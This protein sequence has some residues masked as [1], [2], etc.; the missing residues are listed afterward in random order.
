MTY[1][2]THTMVADIASVFPKDQVLTPA[3]GQAYEEA[4]R[5]WAE[6]SE[7]RAKIIVLPK[8]AEDVSKAVRGIV[9]AA[10]S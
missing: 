9:S 8:S 3:N 6:N 4:L 1:S 10:S 5:R 2:P 7:R